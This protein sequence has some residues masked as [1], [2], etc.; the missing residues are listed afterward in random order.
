MQDWILASSSK[1]RIQLLEEIG[2][3]FRCISPTV[4]EVKQPGNHSTAWVATTNA[5]RKAQSRCV[6]HWS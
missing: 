3:H 1:R 5:Q 2:F 6:R 4:E